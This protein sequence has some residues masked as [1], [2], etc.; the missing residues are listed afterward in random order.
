MRC[1]SA[2]STRSDLQSALDEACGAVLDE[3]DSPVD[4]A[5]VFLSS[6]YLQNPGP[7][8]PLEMSEQ[9]TQR[10]GTRNLLGSSGESIVGNQYELEWQPALALWV[11]S[12]DACR[13]DTFS[14]DFQ[15]RDGEGA[16]VGWPN[17]I[18]DPW[19]AEATLFLLADPFSF[20]ADVFLSRMNEDR[21]GVPV[22]GG[23][24]SGAGAPGEARLVCG[25]DVFDRGAVVARVSGDFRIRSVV[26]QGCRPIGKPL[27]I[28]AGERNEIRQ[29][30]GKPA[31]AQLEQI[32]EAL[33]NREK[34]LVNRGL[35]VG[36]VI[37][38]YQDQFMQGDFL[39][40][41][42]TGIDQ[43]SGTIVIADYVRPGQTVQFQVRDA[44]TAHLDLQQMLQRLPAD[45][46]TPQG[47]LLFTC[48]GRGTRLFPAEHH[49]AA[50]VQQSLGSIPLAGFFAAGE[51]GPVGGRNFLH[52]FT[53][54][55]ALFDSHRETANR[56]GDRP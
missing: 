11:A 10:L 1:A 52:G 44:E 47:G 5:F 6:L 53:A 56:P 15:P 17:W 51:A 45:S 39:I 19:P 8:G 37:S 2:F 26:S 21:P 40:R 31:L 36:R 14:L 33:P 23:V 20:P 48:N 42:V 30:G 28:T 50:L 54:S 4:L 32:F 35:Y 9:L 7:C 55:L 49:D 43:T 25:N 3:L 13:I 29:L 22:I 38:E 46:G 27:V 12:F 41:N 16:F 24:A 34:Q 18:D